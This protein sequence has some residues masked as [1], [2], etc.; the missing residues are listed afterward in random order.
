MKKITII[1][2]NFFFKLLSVLFFSIYYN[3]NVNIYI[4]FLKNIVHIII[5]IH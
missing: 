1:I 5:Y 3:D 2:V 4:F